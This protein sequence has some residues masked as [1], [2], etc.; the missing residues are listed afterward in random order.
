MKKANDVIDNIT[1]KSLASYGVKS[2]E[3]ETAATVSTDL[4]SAT[5]D[6][7]VST[8]PKTKRRIH[9]RTAKQM[10]PVTPRA[11]YAKRYPESQTPSASSR[12]SVDKVLLDCRELPSPDQPIKG[13]AGYTQEEWDKLLTV[14]TRYMADVVEGAG[15]IYRGPTM[16]GVDRWRDGLSLLMQECFRHRDPWD[17]KY[18]SISV[19]GRIES[20]DRKP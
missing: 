10:R 13:Y 6:Y 8:K 16:F 18:R 9:S 2:E 7:G 4:F 20:D 5:D 15:L 17:D 12:A 11:E 14:V 19:N 1:K 3:Q